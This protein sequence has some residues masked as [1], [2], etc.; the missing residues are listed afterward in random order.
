MR[1]FCAACALFL[2]GATPT[3]RPA[4]ADPIVVQVRMVA[5]DFPDDDKPRTPDNVV[6]EA[7]AKK[8][9]HAALSETASDLWR[10]ETSARAGVPFACTALIDGKTYTLN[11]NF[12]R[13]SGEHYGG[14]IEFGVSS[15]DASGAVSTS[16]IKST[17]AIKLEAPF[18]ASWSTPDRRGGR[19]R[20]F[21]LTVKRLSP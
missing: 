3:T 1:L 2:L 10:L 18:L 7:A 16:S 13:G 15:A 20:G 5:F 6:N 12:R 4:Q 14:P 21:I 17:V 19:A 8:I 9:A 11:G